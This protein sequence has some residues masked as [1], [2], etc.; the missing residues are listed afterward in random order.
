M[1]PF[2]YLVFACMFTGTQAANC[3]DIQHC[4]ECDEK[5]GQC[6]KCYPGYWDK[7]CSIKCSDSCRHNTC[8]ITDGGIERCSEGCVTGFQGTNCII[9]CDTPVDNCTECPGGC[10]EEYCKLNSTCV[11]GCVD[12]Y[13]GSGCRPC[14]NRCKSCNRVTG[15]CEECHPPY[16]GR[17]CEHPCANCP[18]SCDSECLKECSSIFYEMFCIEPCIDNCISIID[19]CPLNCSDKDTVNYCTP[20]SHNQSGECTRGCV[21]GWYGPTCSSRCDANCLNH[22]CDLTG[23]CVEGCKIGYFGKNCTPCSETCLNHTCHSNT[24]SCTHGCS[25]GWYGEVCDQTCAVCRDGV[26][27][28][29]TGTCIKGCTISG[30]DPSCTGNC[31]IEEC[32]QAAPCN[33]APKTNGIIITTLGI[34]IGILAATMFCIAL[35]QCV[36]YRKRIA[37]RRRRPLEAVMVNATG[38]V[39]LPTLE[40][41]GLHRYYEL[42]DEDMDPEF[43]G[44]NQLESGMVTDTGQVPTHEYQ[45]IHR[46]Y[47]IHDDDVDPELPGRNTNNP[48]NMVEEEKEEREKKEKKEGAEEESEQATPIL[49]EYFPVSSDEGDGEKSELA[50]PTLGEN[51]PVSSDEGDGEERELATPALDEYFPVSSDVGDGAESELA[52]SALDEYFPV[53]SD[54]GDGEKSELA[55]PTLGENFPVSSDEGDGAESELATPALDEDFPVSSDVEDE[56]DATS[57]ASAEDHSSYIRP[58]RDVFVDDPTTVVTYLS[59]REDSK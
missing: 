44:R 42:H 19:T 41:Q 4:A 21:D 45:V 34:I 9:P 5:T 56:K 12:S 15:T 46:Y 6:L 53:S 33:T 23:T 1:V 31:S 17:D 49:G 10:E 54:E 2:L 7:R 16:V 47:E 8:E 30:C 52:T 3:T 43:P 27:H 25:Q 11:S 22:R 14:S 20:T 39:S 55:T 51:F 57:G 24:G 40:Y 59:P 38:Q 36:R 37:A 13:Y 35:R 32:R 50:T 58:I 29:K 28:Q 26:C 18:G 48:N